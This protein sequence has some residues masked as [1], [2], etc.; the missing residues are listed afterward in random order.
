MRSPQHCHANS[1]CGIGKPIGG[2]NRV[3]ARKRSERISP[4]FKENTI[5]GVGC[6]STSGFFLKKSSSKSHLYVKKERENVDIEGSEEYTFVEKE[7]FGQHEMES[8]KN[9]SLAL[10]DCNYNSYNNKKNERRSAEA[11]R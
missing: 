9:T 8:S 1:I 3:R 5:G 11:E 10:R 4:T 2:K 7:T 6:S